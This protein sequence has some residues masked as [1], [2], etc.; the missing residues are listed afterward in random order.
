MSG[1]CIIGGAITGSMP[2]KTDYTALP[3]TPGEQIE[4]TH[5]APA[6]GHA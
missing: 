2:R 4:S 3:V 6:A 5:A 1:P